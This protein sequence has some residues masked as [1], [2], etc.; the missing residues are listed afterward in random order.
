MF[1]S[2]VRPDRISSPITRMAAVTIELMAFPFCGARYTASRNRRGKRLMNDVQTAV[3]R[4]RIAFAPVEV[5]RT[6][7]P[8]GTIRLASATSLD[9]YEPSLARVFRNS[10]EAAPGR[11]FL[12]ERA[13]DEWR[14]LTY[15]AAR[16]IADSV[17]AALIA[18]GLSA[19]RPVM[20][21]SANS[22][23]HALLTLACFTAGVPVA[24]V[25]VAYSLQS[26]DFAKLKYIAELLDPGL[27]YVADTAPFAKALGA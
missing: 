18:R 10:V 20:I 7:D 27:I 24:P 1:L 19:E 3:S 13:G 25:S 6:T 11:T 4:Q 21:L 8:D 9:S 15:E 17:A 22:I 23:E 5:T 12:Q 14:K 2:L 16:R 26:Q